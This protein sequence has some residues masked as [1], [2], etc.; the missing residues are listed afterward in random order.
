MS[1]IIL[2]HT[3]AGSS[4]D[5]GWVEANGVNPTADF[6]VSYWKI[7]WVSIL[8]FVLFHSSTY[9][10]IDL[11]SSISFQCCVF[12]PTPKFESLQVQTVRCVYWNIEPQHL[13]LWTFS[14]SF[15]FIL[16]NLTPIVYLTVSKYLDTKIIYASYF[17]CDLKY[18]LF[19]ELNLPDCLIT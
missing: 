12:A 10:V 17:A 6:S 5:S 14:K 9:F 13:N 16:G 15:G 7:D 2:V 19:Q 1:L 11:T 3:S 8:A 18:K 4:S